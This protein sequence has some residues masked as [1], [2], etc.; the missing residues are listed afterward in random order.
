MGIK[1]LKQFI[2][3]KFSS[4]IQP[5][6][7][8]FFRGKKA[9]IDLLPYLYKYKVGFGH[10]W[11][12]GLFYLF[13]SCIKQNIHLTVIMDG[14]MVGKEKDKEREKRKEGRTR[15]QNK[16][17]QWI[18]DLDQYKKTR[19]ATPL[20]Y[21]LFKTHKNLVMDTE[22]K[23]TINEKE[24]ERH[25]QKLKQQMVIIS[26]DD[27]VVIKNLCS[28]LSIPF[29]MASQE[30]ESFS[31]FLCKSKQV[32]LVITEDTDVLAYGC[33]LWISS[34][35]P[36]GSCNEVKIDYLLSEMK[37]S[38]DQFVDFCILCG[39]DYNETIKKVGIV[40]AYKAINQYNTIETFL[41]SIVVDQEQK[42]MIQQDMV[43]TIFNN[44]CNDVMNDD[45]SGTKK[46]T[47]LFNELPI[48]KKV[49]LLDDYPIQSF[50]QWI[51][52]YPDQFDLE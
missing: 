41:E 7:L 27:I 11:R 20:L 52:S 14:P 25:I 32:D 23:P 49:L 42:Q 43:R 21:S 40:S 10:N 45:H 50:L 4:C 2:R 24:V 46:I 22:V 5:S 39:T 51:Y 26:K 47:I 34:I 17:D 37:L 19:E 8:S 9:A 3:S 29:Y 35:S 28:S 18:L 30:A 44:P 1:G 31:T 48:E 38:Y 15:I 6:H 16:V 13:T 33:P 36:D 12:H